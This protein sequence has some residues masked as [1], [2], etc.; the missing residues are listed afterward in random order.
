LIADYFASFHDARD[1]GFASAMP[2]DARR[3]EQRE[4]DADASP[5]IAATPFF[6]AHAADAARRFDIFILFDFHAFIAPLP[7]CC[8]DF[9]PPPLRQM[10]FARHTPRR[11]VSHFRLILRRH[12]LMARDALYC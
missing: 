7:P 3:E 9:S 1:A 6:A 8:F 2:R 12:T 4:S 11:H 5:D 10:P